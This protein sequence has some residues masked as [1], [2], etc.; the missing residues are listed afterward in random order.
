[1]L[2]AENRLSIRAIPLIR[3]IRAGSALPPVPVVVMSATK[4]LPK[5]MRKQWTSLQAGLTET[6]TRG[7]HIIAEDTGHAIH[8]ERPEQVANAVIDVV[9]RIRQP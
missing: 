5:D 8:Q 2:R 3:Q 6:A 1:M 4:G 9:E 7:Q